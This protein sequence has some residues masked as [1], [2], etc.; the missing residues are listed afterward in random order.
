MRRFVLR[1][2]GAGAALVRRLGGAAG[3]RRPV[4]AQAGLAITTPFP[5]VSVQPGQSVSFDLTV[6]ADEPSRV[7][8]ALEGLPDGW[9]GS[10]SGGGNEVQGVFVDAG[11][12]AQVTLAIQV[13]DDAEAGATPVT[14]IGR[15]GG[16]TARLELDLNVVEAGGGTVSLESDFPSLRGR[17]TRTSSSA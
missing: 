11:A 8:L 3:P 15:S 17:S 7:D 9:E 4:A 13:P 6:S 16:T 5:A 1:R 12:P 10:M 2:M 14:V